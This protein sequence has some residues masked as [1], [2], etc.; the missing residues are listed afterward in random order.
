MKRL[1][2]LVSLCLVSI[3]LT[4]CGGD[5]KDGGLL[6]GRNAPGAT[7][8]PTGVTPSALIPTPGGRTPAPQPTATPSSAN[9]E[10]WQIAMLD[11]RPSLP[12]EYIPPHPGADGRVCDVK[13]CINTMDD[14]N[15]VSGTIP[16]CTTSQRTAGNVSNPLCYNSDPPT[17][18]PHAPQFATNRVYDTAVPKEQLVHT[19]EHAAVIIWYST[20]DQNVIRT[21]A[22]ITNGANQSGKFVVMTPYTGMGP[23]LIALTSWTRLQKFPVSQFRDQTVID[24]I[25][26]HSKRYNPEGF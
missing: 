11:A 7:Q 17:S 9:R 18:G 12:G 19:M 3:V 22:Q 4:G 2:L 16:I 6:S 24:F 13:S 21:L 5:D 10:A 25:N 20:T 15:H 23:D 26:A 1:L 8:G 14:R